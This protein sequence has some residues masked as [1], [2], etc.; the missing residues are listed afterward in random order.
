MTRIDPWRGTEGPFMEETPAETQAEELRRTRAALW[1]EIAKGSQA[2]TK[3][4]ILRASIAPRG[5]GLDVRA[6]LAEIIKTL[7]GTP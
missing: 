2:I 4:H 5:D 1:D 3:L 6:R 7:G